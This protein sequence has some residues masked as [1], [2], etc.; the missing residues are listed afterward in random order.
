[1]KFLFLIIA[2]TGV[3][4]KAS[5]FDSD[6]E[7]DSPRTQKRQFEK[8]AD[9]TVVTENTIKGKCVTIIYGVHKELNG[10]EKLQSK[11]FYDNF[12]NITQEIIYDVDGK[13]NRKIIIFRVA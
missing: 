6:P 13:K 1:M 9:I 11:T 10:S 8:I 4:F 7:T 3:S 5:A 12:S 2:L